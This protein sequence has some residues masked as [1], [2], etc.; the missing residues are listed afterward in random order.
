MQR[1]LGLKASNEELRDVGVVM[2]FIQNEV[3]SSLKEFKR[4]AEYMSI[5]MDSLANE[6]L[7]E[8]RTAVELKFNHSNLNKYMADQG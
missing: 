7:N 1:S 4:H 3:S 5:S 2:G 8:V 6:G